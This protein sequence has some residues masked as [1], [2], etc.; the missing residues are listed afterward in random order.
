MSTNIYFN[1]NLIFRLHNAQCT[2][3]K[4]K[5]NNVQVK[6]IKDRIEEQEM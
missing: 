1:E 2:F 5:Y 4:T 3:A 6:K